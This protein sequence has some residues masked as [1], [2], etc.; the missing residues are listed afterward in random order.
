MENINVCVVI[1]WVFFNCLV[2]IKVSR[3]FRILW[4]FGLIFYI[5]GF[6]F[7]YIDLSWDNFVKILVVLKVV[8]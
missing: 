3:L 6:N 5:Y 8:I 1:I 7:L 2:V 4:L